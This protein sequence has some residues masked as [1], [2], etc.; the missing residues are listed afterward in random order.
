MFLRRP[1]DAGR[2]Q[3][4]ALLSPSSL[5]RIDSCLACPHVADRVLS[6]CS[7]SVKDLPGY[8][9]THHAPTG[10]KMIRA[11]GWTP[12][13]PEKR[14]QRYKLLTKQTNLSGEMLV[15]EV[16][17]PSMTSIIQSTHYI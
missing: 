6:L 11:R 9:D 17:F 7:Q 5:Y 13:L 8:T 4:P 10:A 15:I 2:M 14:V 16:Y 3:G 1:A 12:T